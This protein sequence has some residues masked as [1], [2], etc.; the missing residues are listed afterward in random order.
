MVNEQT[1]FYVFPGHK[2]L[3]GKMC[4]DRIDLNHSSCAM[5]CQQLLETKFRC[6]LNLKMALIMEPKEGWR[7]A[8]MTSSTSLFP[9]KGHSMQLGQ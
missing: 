3:M 8:I 2:M 1:E 5:L 4:L 6:L 7:R 9:V